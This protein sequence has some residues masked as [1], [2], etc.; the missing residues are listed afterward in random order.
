MTRHA[1]DSTAARLAEAF[2]REFATVPALDEARRETFLAIRL[3][4]A[5]YAVRTAEIAGLVTDRR[6]VPLPS[7]EPSLLGVA[8]FRGRVVPVYD[9]AALLGHAARGAGRW[10]L[11]VDGGEAA[12][13]ITMFEAQLSLAAGERMVAAQALASRPHLSGAV[14]A[15]G[16]VRPVADLPSVMNEIRKRA[17]AARSTKGD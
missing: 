12:L 14:E 15:G 8:S 5:P 3:G 6:V 17:Q 10:L 1:T 13:S 9:L 2:D 4:D 7:S 11:L 16:I